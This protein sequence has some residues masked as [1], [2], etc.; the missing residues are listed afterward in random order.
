MS[1]DDKKPGMSFWAT[2]VV[3]CLLIAYPV[4]YG[5]L[6]R[7][8]PRIPASLRPMMAIAYWPLDW[9][10]IRGPDQP[11]RR[12]LQWYVGLWISEP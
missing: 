4:S 2:V 3:V 8:N 9:I 10:Y 12:P 5:P 7:F 11:L 1:D 6:A